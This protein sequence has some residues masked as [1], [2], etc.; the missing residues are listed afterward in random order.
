MHISLQV[1][2][3]EVP[4]RPRPTS[5]E[6]P[7]RA[8]RRA[9]DVFAFLVAIAMAIAT[10]ATV[11]ACGGSSARR[12][13]PARSI[14]TV[15]I[16]EPVADAPDAGPDAPASTREWARPFLWRIEGTP[17]SY[18][19]GTVHLPDARLEPLLPSVQRALDASEVV[20]AE[21][22]MDAATRSE[23]ASRSL[24]PAG[25]SLKSEIPAD[26]YARVQTLLRARH[27]PPAAVARVRVWALALQITLLDHLAALVT[28]KPLDLRLY[29][30]AHDAGKSVG[31]L[32]TVDE[33]MKVFDGLSRAEQAA[34]LRKTLDD[35]DEYKKRGID[36]I[37]DLLKLYLAGDEAKTRD[38]FATMFDPSKSLDALLQKRVL[39]DRNK[40]MTDRVQARIEAT[41]RR[42][43][44][45]AVG[46]AHLLGDD[47]VVAALAKRG[48]KLTRLGAE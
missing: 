35:A 47:S 25:R 32:E 44:F 43:H 20:L 27:I 11:P 23:L 40:V 36:P 15:A 9:R 17:P 6:A 2:L 14:D 18:L 13:A 45:V 34:L 5:F 8:G 46:A 3:A 39:D 29:E 37:E 7:S 26:L 24:L 33:Q 41:P 4:L 42:A 22:P 1:S 12:D 30:A 48:Y 21:L 19:F 28:M 16:R 10:V 38:A 31:G